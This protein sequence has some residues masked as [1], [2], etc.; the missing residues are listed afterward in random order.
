MCMTLTRDAVWK[1]LQPQSKLAAWFAQLHQVGFKPTFPNLGK[2]VVVMMWMWSHM[3]IYNLRRHSNTS[4]MYDIDMG[5]SLKGSAAS[6]KMLW[7][8]LHTCI[9]SNFSQ[10]SQIWGSVCGDSGVNMKPYAHPH[11]EKALKSLIYVRHW[12]GMQLNGST[13]STKT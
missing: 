1:V 12:H 6:A 4:H 5:C 13:A 10:P 9:R 8:G 3:P 11:P 7:H 2:S